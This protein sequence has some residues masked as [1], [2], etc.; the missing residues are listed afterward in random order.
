[1][2]NDQG[3]YTEAEPLMK[4]ALTIAE[5]ALGPDHPDVGSDLNILA[6]LYRNQGRYAEAEPLM[7]RAL[8]IAEKAHDDRN[9]A[10]A[11]KELSV[12]YEN[13]GRF[14]EE[15]PLIKRALAIDEKAYGR[16][17]PDIG[18][19]L[20]L[21]ARLYRHQGRNTEAEPLYRRALAIEEKTHA[22]DHPDVGTAVATLGQLLYDWGRYAEA[23][24]L[25]KRALE[26]HQKAY[27]PDHPSVGADLSNMAALYLSQHDWQRAA[28]YWR[29]STDVSIRRGQRGT[30][31][32]DE[33]LTGKKKSE[34]EQISWQFQG[35][36]KVAHRLASQD[37]AQTGWS[38]EMFQTAQWAQ[39]SEAARSVSQM[40]AR[41]A[42]GDPKL[43]GVVRER[44]DLVTEWERRD[45]LR[46]A[47]VA[48]TPDKRNKEIEAE[49]VARLAAIDARIAEIDRRLKVDDPDYVTFSHPTPLSIEA[50][51]AQ[52]GSDEALV[53]FLDTPWIG[54]MLGETFIWVVTKTD[55]R[56]VHSELGT[57]ALARDVAALRCG[58]DYEGA[59]VG[60][61]CN[62]LLNSNITPGVEAPLP[63]DLQ[64]AHAM[65]KELFGQV[66]DLI[67]DKQLLIVPSGP[68]TQ[69]PFSVLV[70]RA[71]QVA[72]PNTFAGYRDVAWLARS[73]AITM[74]PA[75]SSLKALR[76]FAKQSHASNPYIGF[77]DPLLDGDPAHYPDDAVRA[78]RAREARC[79][80][81]PTLRERVASLFKPRAAADVFA[82]GTRGAIQVADIR[83]QLPLPE[84][85]DELCDVAIDLRVDPSKYV[86]LG[87]R[88]TEAEIKRLSDSG[89]LAK[90]R[91]VQFA[92]HGFIAG[93]LTG[94]SEPGLLLTPPDKPSDTDDGYLSASEVAALKLDADWV[95]LSACN[96]A[97]GDT[98]DADALSGLARAFFYAGARSLLVSHW[99]VDSAATVDLITKA[100]GEIKSNP[101]I[102]RAEALRRSML[103]MIDSSKDH[104]AH[105]AFW[106]PFV[107]VGEG[108]SRR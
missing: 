41:G 93:D 4:R 13:Q 94:A 80:S 101:N 103:A 35:L 86:Y 3:R 1:M 17:H 70:T 66:E 79:K 64:R 73:H 76:E 43:A 39:A 23:E 74:L 49:N 57:L 22:P 59:W 62:E 7:K 105:P 87:A 81:T 68:L 20:N 95:I 88:A 82:R 48:Q 97:A 40:A 42:K 6:R 34:T 37:R 47:A 104:E 84:T 26:I 58:L 71:P 8:A 33:T 69:L 45:Q 92:T 60:T 10:G 83:R 9:V 67:K 30:L 25:D 102:G 63:F 15:E 28:D 61:R 14:A 107:L 46:S 77:G 11:L 91:I 106:A 85:A 96:T 32:A 38:R 24:S 12:L 65:Y 53:L 52:L 5:T 56:W 98:K 90:H 16:D 31:D 78:K 21:L 36:V 100:V 75:V 89:D 54:P 72:L 50:V 99:S 51:Q 19:D 29:A 27:G 44:Q 55:L 18:V 2:Y 108:G